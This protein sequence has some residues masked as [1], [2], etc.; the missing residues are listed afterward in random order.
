MPINNHSKLPFFS[1]EKAQSTRTP[2]KIKDIVNQA[3]LP[4]SFMCL[5]HNT[6]TVHLWTATNS[7][8]IQKAKQIQSSCEITFSFGLLTEVPASWRSWGQ[9]NVVWPKLGEDGISVPDNYQQGMSSRDKG[10]G[11]FRRSYHYNRRDS[12]DAFPEG[13]LSYYF[14][15]K[16]PNFHQLFGLI[17]EQHVSLKTISMETTRNL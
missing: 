2:I 7:I 16:I 12:S 6:H 9:R 14:I 11:C 4:F 8:C 15:T 5:S 13:L 3:W 10:H 17:K 1:Q